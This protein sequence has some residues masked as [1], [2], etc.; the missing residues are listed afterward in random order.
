MAGVGFDRAQ[1]RLGEDDV[2]VR[3][4]L[5]LHQTQLRFLEMD[6]VAALGVAEVRAVRIGLARLRHLVLIGAVVHPVA[7]PVAAS[8][9]EHRAVMA[10]VSFPGRIGHQS[11]VPPDR[12]VELQPGSPR[13]AVDEMFVHHELEARAHVSDLLGGAHD[14]GS[15][16]EHKQDHE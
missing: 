12:M 15:R 10:G 8:V 13:H 2:V 4:A 3:A 14:G 11:H 5:K 9:L 1:R 6:A 7:H 16:A